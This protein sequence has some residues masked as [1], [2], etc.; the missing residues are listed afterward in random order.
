MHI[1]PENRC[2][3]AIYS[4]FQHILHEYITNASKTSGAKSQ[5][6]YNYSPKY[7]YHYHHQNSTAGNDTEQKQKGKSQTESPRNYITE[8]IK[9][10]RKL[11]VGERR[12]ER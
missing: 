7:S 8:E 6:R 1:H 5:G 9:K 12:M 10:N 11:K 4:I 3:A 2:K